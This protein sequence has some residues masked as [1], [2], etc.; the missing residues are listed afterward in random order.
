MFHYILV[1]F[2][3]TPGFNRYLAKGTDTYFSSSAHNDVN[4]R[5]ANIQYYERI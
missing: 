2:Y 4:E 1:G 5:G 3:Y